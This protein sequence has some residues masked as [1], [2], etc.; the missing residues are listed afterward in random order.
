M[1]PNR[2]SRFTGGCVSQCLSTVF[3]I[4]ADDVGAVQSAIGG[5]DKPVVLVAH[6]YGGQVATQ[7]GCATWP[8]GTH[9]SCRDRLNWPRFIHADAAALT[10]P[11]AAAG[12]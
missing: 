3:N 2:S 8:V 12:V 9:R 1:Q 7:A 11:L 5:F 4:F 10:S 6:S